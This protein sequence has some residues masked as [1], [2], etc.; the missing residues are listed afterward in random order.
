M[1]LGVTARK[2][3]LGHSERTKGS[4]NEQQCRRQS[5]TPKAWPVHLVHG[6]ASTTARKKG[7]IVPL[8]GC[9]R[10]RSVPHNHTSNS[11]LRTKVHTACCPMQDGK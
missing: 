9:S 7:V 10:Q 4:R 11:V 1:G 3:P 6:I 8:D 5:L 2:N